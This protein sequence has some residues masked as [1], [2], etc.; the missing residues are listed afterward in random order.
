MALTRHRSVLQDGSGNGIPGAT[1]AVV[2]AN[3]TTAAELFSDAEGLSPIVGNIVLTS[4]VIPGQYSFYV[5][6]GTY[7]MTFTL[8]G[9]IVATLEDVLVVSSNK[10][11]NIPDLVADYDLLPTDGADNSAAFVAGFAAVPT[12]YGL[13]ARLLHLSDVTL[14]NNKAFFGQMS[15]LQAAE[16]GTHLF[17]LQ[18]FHSTVRDVYVAGALELSDAVIRF[19]TGR[20]QR[21]SDVFMV[22]AGVG[23]IKMMPDSGS[24][25]ISYITNVVAEGVTGIG[26]DMGSSVNDTQVS[27]LYLSGKVDYA[28]GLGKPRAG[29]VGWRQNT[30]VVGGLAVGGHQVD[31]LTVINQQEGIHVTDGQY[32]NFGNLIADS[33][34]SYGV[35]VDGASERINFN[36]L[37]V[38][39]TRGIRVSG[40]SSINIDGLVTT[41]TGVV[42]PWGQV[43]FY[44]AAAPYYDITVQNTAVVRING[45][46]WVGDKRVFVDPGADL[47]VTGGQRMEFRS[48]S[49]VADSTITFLGPSGNT[50]TE[51]DATIRV[52][53]DGWLF[54]AAAA[55]TVAPGATF[56]YTYN[57]RIAGMNEHS[58]VI[59]NAEF[60]NKS[61]AYEVPVLE[62]QEVSV[63]LVVPTGAGVARHQCSVQLLGK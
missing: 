30:P 14:S 45:D 36:D 61:W 59:A 18:G 38:G 60:A 17:N 52:E 19:N 46:A 1:V 28:L 25:A 63:Q 33:C 54:L 7:D 26:L 48:T 62:G 58:V 15:R 55:V 9:V 22:D 44:D 10:L 42:P 40:S 8:N 13:P 6:G 56:G 4:A 53:R 57:I 2:I 16:G 35:I 47:I 12:L 49:T 31:F 41:L 21:L 20:V 11:A 27:H 39:T 34:T 5:E 50:A 43:G 23:A 32:T 29:N 51:Q 3:T 24:C 37:F